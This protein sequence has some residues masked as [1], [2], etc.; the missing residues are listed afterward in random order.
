M[1]TGDRDLPVTGRN[2]D[3]GIALRTDVDFMV[4]VFQV[5][6][7]DFSAGTDPTGPLHEHGIFRAS[8]GSVFG[9]KA[10]H[11]KHKHDQIKPTE[12]LISWIQQGPKQQDKQDDV[13]GVVEWIGSVTADHETG[14]GTF[15]LIEHGFPLHKQDTS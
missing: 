12:D 10:K 3:L 5:E 11:Q 2:S 8:F 4:S 7:D 15:E 6:D 14:N 9:Q 1:G 13:K